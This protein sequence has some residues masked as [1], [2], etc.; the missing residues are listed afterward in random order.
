MWGTQNASA[1]RERKHILEESTLG[2]PAVVAMSECCYDTC[3]PQLWMVDS[4]FGDPKRVASLLEATTL[5]TIGGIDLRRV[6][7]YARRLS[8][9]V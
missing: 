7:L 8:N 3:S 4:I 6:E 2:S 9:T 1:L 5:N